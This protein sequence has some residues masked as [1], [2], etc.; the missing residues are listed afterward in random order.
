MVRG[1]TEKRVPELFSKVEMFVGSVVFNQMGTTS[2]DVIN[3]M[4]TK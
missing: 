1:D 3:Q 2:K 4:T